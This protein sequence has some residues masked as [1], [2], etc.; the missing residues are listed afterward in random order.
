MPRFKLEIPETYD[1]ITRPVVYGVANDLVR[2]FSLPADMGVRIQGDNLSFPQKS[3]PL[4]NQNKEFGLPFTPKLDI[5]FTETYLDIETLKGQQAP[6]VFSDPHIGVFIRPFYTRVRLEVEMELRSENKNQGLRLRDHIKRKMTEGVQAILHEA[7]YHYSTPKPMLTLLHAIWTCREEVAGYNQSYNDYL[8]SHFTPNLTTLTNQSGEQTLSAI[9]ERQ[10]ELQG[11]FD[12]ESQP[13]NPERKTDEGTFT[14][15]FTYTFEFDKPIALE[16]EY[17][18]VVH[19]QLLD[20]AFVKPREVYNSATQIRGGNRLTKTMDFFRS[21][22]QLLV[23]RGFDGVVIPHY[24]DFKPVKQGFKTFDLLT[25]LVGVDPE[26]PT[27]ILNLEDI[28]EF[29]LD[30]AVIGFMKRHHTKLTYYLANVFHL[31]F[32]K[33]SM[34]QS[35]DTV[36]V[37]ESLNIRT[38]EPM[39]LRDVHHF[40]L[41]MV[42]DPR[43]LSRQAI[44]DLLADHAVCAMVIDLIEQNFK[45]VNGG[46]SIN[47]NDFDPSKPRRG[48]FT[49]YPGSEYYTKPRT[50]SPYRQADGRSIETG[51]SVEGQNETTPR[52]TPYRPGTG[53]VTLDNRRPKHPTYQGKGSGVVNTG[54]WTDQNGNHW[55]FYGDGTGWFYPAHGEWFLFIAGDGSFWFYFEGFDNPVIFDNNGCFTFTF[56]EGTFSYCQGELL[57]ATLTNGGV[58]SYD[59]SGPFY[60]D[61][62][63]NTRWRYRDGK[64]YYTDANGIEQEVEV[65]GPAAQYIEGKGPIEYLP[66]FDIDELLA[67]IERLLLQLKDGGIYHPDPSKQPDKLSDQLVVIGNKR[68]SDKSFN[69]CITRAKPGNL[70]GQPRGMMTV[71][72]AGI[73]ARKMTT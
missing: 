66:D 72:R 41:S 22:Q 25:T 73:L 6:N 34:C 70:Y 7:Y 63:N 57:Y 52:G 13:D 40:K 45:P 61:D 10:I 68:V 2:N 54:W 28:D 36:V 42:E 71:M 21:T 1:S 37:D 14:T 33:G 12:F 18:I 4:E 62:I 9:S 67:V 51:V 16:V 60:F 55:Y 27:F 26:D 23:S 19:N 8:L 17:P 46:T 20:D 5:T 11:W 58:W 56:T 64:V 47:P 59:L 32:Y 35:F 50:N 29:S 44:E 24:D 43:T 38:T 69:E 65:D 30:P 53:G 3:T 39:A 15:T 48:S 31:T 49:Q